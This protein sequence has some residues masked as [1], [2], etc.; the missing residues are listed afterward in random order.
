MDDILRKEIEQFLIDYEN[1]IKD[2]DNMDLP[3]T[4]AF[5]KASVGYLTEIVNS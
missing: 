2:E 5:L 3:I 4:D 1:A